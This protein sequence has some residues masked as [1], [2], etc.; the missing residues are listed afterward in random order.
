L[1][2][3]LLAENSKDNDISSS[4]AV[5]R[6]QIKQVVVTDVN[7]EYHTN[8]K[9]EDMHNPEKARDVA[10]K[11]LMLL[12]KRYP[13][14]ADD[15]GWLCRAYACGAVGANRYKGYWYLARAEKNNQQKGKV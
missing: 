6:Y 5:G 13:E 15:V 9:L 4:G 14:K 7:N 12:A 10:S 2:L 1:Q 11:L 3:I 8:Y